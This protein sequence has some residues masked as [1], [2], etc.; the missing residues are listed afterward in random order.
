VLDIGCGW[1]GLALYLASVADV[2]VTGVTLAEEQLRVAEAR[3][4]EAGLSER[5][6]FE[7][8]DYREVKE[9]FDRVISVGMLEH[10]GIT[11]LD[12]YFMKVRDVL[13][14]G[15]VAMIHSISGKSPPGITGPFLRK[16]IFPGGYAPSVSEA[17][18]SVER[19]GLW[20]LDMEIWRVHYAPTLRNW[21]YRFM[22]RRDEVVR[23]F[24]ERFAR[25]WEFYLAA[26]ECAFRYGSSHVFQFQLARERDAM[27]LHRDYVPEAERR[28]AARE[29]QALPAIDAAT[30]RVF[31]EA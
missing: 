13:K 16:Y 31:A 2:H 7:L 26:C 23:M 12:E 24:D 14:P 9:T 1:G 25:M 29:G 17:M 30:R 11:H 10:V 18:A 21:R 8:R 15:G 19:S 5:V 27:P 3:A 22:S 4:R 28:L 20:L 6:T